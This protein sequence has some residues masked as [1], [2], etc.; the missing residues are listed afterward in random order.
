MATELPEK[1][2]RSYV[3]GELKSAQTTD[4][5]IL[6]AV[7]YRL[8]APSKTA[9]KS[10]WF[11]VIFGLVL[12]GTFVGLIITAMAVPLGTMMI[13]RGRHNIRIVEK[14]YSEFLG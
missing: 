11:L 1:L 10:G 12:A 9:Y 7:K 14:T 4:P 3:L 8:L 13:L 5:D 2:D 6:Y